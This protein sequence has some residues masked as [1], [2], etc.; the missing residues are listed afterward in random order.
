MSL[1]PAFKIGLWNAW[2]FMSVFL[3]QILVIMLADKRIWERSHVPTDARRN[4]LERYCLDKYG[5]A[6]QEY[7][8]SVPR[9]FGVPKR[10]E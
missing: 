10:I 5:S 1:I 6:Y 4:K 2:I 7:L 9:W 3:L 8:N